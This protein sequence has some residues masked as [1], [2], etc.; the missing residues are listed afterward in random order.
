[1]TSENLSAPVVSQEPI[2]T[3][4]VGG[5]GLSPT[6]Y[7]GRIGL[8]NLGNTCF[9]NSVLQCLIHLPEFMN[10]IRSWEYLH[11]FGLSL[12]KYVK[13]KNLPNTEENIT[14]IR[15]RTTSYRFFEVATCM[16]KHGGRIRPTNLHNSL[17][18]MQTELSARK[19]YEQQQVHQFNKFNKLQQE[20]AHD[21]FTHIIDRLH[22][23]LSSTNI[24]TFINPEPGVVAFTQKNDIYMKLI[25]SDGIS[26]EDKL[27]ATTELNK[28]RRE[29]H[30]DYMAYMSY[31]AWRKYVEFYGHSA[32]SNLFDSI[33]NTRVTC[34]TC[35]TTSNTFGVQ[36]TL[37]LELVLNEEKKCTIEGC[38]N[39]FMRSELLHGDES[40]KCELCN[41]KMPAVKEYRFWEPAKYLVVQLKRFKNASMGVGNFVGERI[42]TPI[43]YGHKLN[44]TPWISRERNTAYTYSLV[45]VSLH[46][47]SLEGGHY[48]AY[49]KVGNKWYD[50]DDAVTPAP[51]VSADRA[52]GADSSAYL[53][54]YE[55][56]E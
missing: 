32:V 42:N 45:A 24:I 4:I 25:T 11:D 18:R 50:Y 17:C 37:A 55:L 54:F 46:G 49:A 41:K 28:Y 39:R 43:S 5:D 56:D 48:T 47:G 14:A 9:M 12:T 30:M 31:E 1:M 13:D 27:V 21:M 6:D 44:I 52:I 2:N 7:A 22:S 16:W 33:Y 23:E 19:P 53:L 34:V 29:N 20:D 10:Y 3:I 36:R 15:D 38:I 35:N 40:Y 26:E 51:Q 8:A